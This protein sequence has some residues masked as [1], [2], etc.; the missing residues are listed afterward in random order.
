MQFKIMG[1]IG[2]LFAVVWIMGC[3]LMFPEQPDF[4]AVLDL[5]TIAYL[6]FMSY[7]VMTI[8]K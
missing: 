2:L 8:K 1:I 5:V 7:L 3:A 6:G 4:W